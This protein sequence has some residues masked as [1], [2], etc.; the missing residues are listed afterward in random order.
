MGRPCTDVRASERG[1][2]GGRQE[3]GAK[4]G[5]GLVGKIDWVGKNSMG[6]AGTRIQRGRDRRMED[7]GLEKGVRAGWP[8]EPYSSKAGIQEVTL[9]YFVAENRE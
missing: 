6:R 1:G 5:A 4:E 8:P 2:K 9:S 7:I 3:W